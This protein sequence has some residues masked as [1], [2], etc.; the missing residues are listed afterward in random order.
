ML[1]NPVVG[2]QAFNAPLGITFDNAG[3]LWVANNFA[4]PL[5]V[6]TIVEISQAV[7]SVAGGVTPVLPRTVLDSR[8]GPGGLPTINNPWGILFDGSG[9]MW[10]TNEQLSVSACSGT[11][12]EFAAGT[13]T[14]PGAVT[15]A[16]NVV[17]GPTAISGTSSLCDPNG[18]TMNTAGN[19]VVANAAGN[20]LAQYTASQ[21][22]SSGNT[23]PHTFIVGA[24]TLLRA[25]TGLTFGPITLR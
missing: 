1:T 10:F 16:A 23:L 21:I 8:P 5:T 22:T 7:L 20:S 25:P 19:R 4:G 2:P 6:S 11:V 18:I 17:I 24:A 13:F 9:N 15:P 12:V 14:G 3:N